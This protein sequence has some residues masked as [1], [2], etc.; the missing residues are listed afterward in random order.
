MSPFVTECDVR[1]TARGRDRCVPPARSS[2]RGCYLVVMAEDFL[3]SA[4]A[5]EASSRAPHDPDYPLFH[6]APPVGRL[7]DPNGLIEV[8]RDLSRV[9]P[10][11][12]R[13][14]AQ[15]RLLGPRH[16]A[17]PDPLGLPRP[18]DPARHPP[19]RERRLLGH[20]DRG[21]RPRRAVVHRQLQGPRDGGARGHPVRRDH[22]R[23]GH[24]STSLCPRSSP[25]SR[26]GT[27]PTSATRRCGATRTAPTGCCSASSA[28][29][30][31]AR[32]CSTAPRTCARGSARGR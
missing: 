14:P 26:R 18:R 30:S 15:A 20:G 16:V 17:R 22:D 1:L 23:H 7:N 25:A 27:R 21:R 19:G 12:A 6:V 11:H 8:G 9:L 10:V 32:P 3:A 4:L 5:A 31:R 24:T 13:A 28:R 2:M 29:T